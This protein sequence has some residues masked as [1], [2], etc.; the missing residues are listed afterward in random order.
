MAQLV[1][2]MSG[3]VLGRVARVVGSSLNRDKIFTASIGLVDSL[4]LSVLIYCVNLHR[5]AMTIAVDLGR[6]A[7][8]QTNDPV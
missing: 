5:P 6:K 4:C 2:S 7:T 1:A 8:K 3:V